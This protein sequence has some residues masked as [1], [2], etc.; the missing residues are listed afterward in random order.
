MS[1]QKDL[2]ILASASQIRKKIL[3]SAGLEFS[4]LPSSVDEEKIKQKNQ[5]LS[6]IDLAMLLASEKALSVSTK[7]NSL[8]IGA[9]QILEIDG[10][11]LDKVRNMQ[12]ARD[13]LWSLRGR[14]HF[15][16]GACVL[17]R[18]GKILW[19]NK[20]K[21]RLVMN[22][23]S[24]QLLDKVMRISGERLLKSVGCYELEAETICL[25]KEIDGDYTAMLG[26]SLL[27]LLTALQK[28]G[29]LIK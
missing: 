6:P 7:N 5:N 8:V 24:P 10:K 18:N 13:R 20:Q 19:N 29:V 2:L 21:S 16:V 3:L 22:E 1:I 4:I 14:E 11:S 25:F 23:F 28:L 12:E 9:D 27:P 17:A 26:L 15:L